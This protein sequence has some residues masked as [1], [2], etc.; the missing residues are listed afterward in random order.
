MFATQELTDIVLVDFFISNVYKENE[1]SEIL[2]ITLKYCPPEIKF[3]DL[4]YITPKA[5]IFNFGMFF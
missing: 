1:G 2:G 4:S 5:D 3:K